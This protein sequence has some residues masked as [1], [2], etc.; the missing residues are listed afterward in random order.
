MTIQILKVNDECLSQ[1]KYS[2]LIGNK[3]YAGNITKNGLTHWKELLSRKKGWLETKHVDDLYKCLECKQDFDQ[4]DFHK[5]SNLCHGC[6]NY[7]ETR[8]LYNRDRL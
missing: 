5:P 8:D 7:Q 6:N 1:P 3:F 2:I 4:Q